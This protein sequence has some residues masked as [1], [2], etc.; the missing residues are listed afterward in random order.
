VEREQVPEPGLVRRT[1]RRRGPEPEQ[2]ALEQERAPEPVRRTDRPS[3]QV[4]GP[5]VRP[6]R[7]LER[8]QELEQELVRQTDRPLGL[9]RVQER[10]GSPAQEPVRQ[11]GHRSAP[12][13]ERVTG[14]EPA[15]H[16]TGLP[17]PVLAG[18]PG[19]APVLVRVSHQT[20]LLP[21]PEPVRAREQELAQVPGRGPRQVGW[22]E[23]EQE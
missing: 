20:G 13:P 2:A 12:G 22:L 6:A 4:P 11:T 19:R 18:S 3:V 7:A 8:V 23:P 16:Q 5:E 21:E 1:G 14:P 10:A 15:F 9:A 17:V